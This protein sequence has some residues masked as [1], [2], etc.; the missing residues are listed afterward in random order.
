MSGDMVMRSIYL[1]PELDAE[2]RR[3][4]FEKGVTKDDLI[5]AA[6]ASKVG[7]W[8]ETGLIHRDL[9]NYSASSDTCHHQTGQ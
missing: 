7:E 2:I 9:G 1:P 4:A 5:R 6:I 8:A 3:F